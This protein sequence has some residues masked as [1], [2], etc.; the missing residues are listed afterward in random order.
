MMVTKRSRVCRSKLDSL[1]RKRDQETYSEITF[2]AFAF[3][4]KGLAS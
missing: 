2:I 1:F 3:V 4:T